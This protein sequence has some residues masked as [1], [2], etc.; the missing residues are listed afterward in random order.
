MVRFFFIYALQFLH[1]M[2]GGVVSQLL[3]TAV[4]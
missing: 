3:R 2:H 4:Q 1:V